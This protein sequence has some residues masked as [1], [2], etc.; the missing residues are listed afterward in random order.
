MISGGPAAE[1]LAQ[2]VNGAREVLKAAGWT[3]VGGSPTF[4]NDDS[5]LGM[6]QMTDLATG[7]P[8]SW[9]RGHG[10]WLALVH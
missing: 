9:R 3:E 5:A 8:E 6:Q 10:R 2:R 1:N 4:C 7:N